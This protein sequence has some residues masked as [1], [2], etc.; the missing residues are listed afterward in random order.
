[1]GKTTIS[2]TDMTWSPLRVRVR[3][4]AAQIARANGY[5]S[6]IQIAG[7][8]AGHVGPHCEHV[9]D[10]CKN[11]YS[12]TNNGRCLPANGTG[13]PFDRRSRDLVY[14]F[15]D[16]NILTQ[17]LRWKKP[18]RVFVENQSDLFG[19][20]VPDE[21][22]DRVF[23]VMQACHWNTFQCLTKRP[24]RALA[25]LTR[26]ATLRMGPWTT[27]ADRARWIAFEDFTDKTRFLYGTKWP[28]PNIW[29]GISCEDQKTADERSRY[30][31]QVPAVVR[32]ISQE[33]QISEIDWAPEALSGIHWLVQG[34]ESGLGARPFWVDWAR[35]TKQQCRAASVAYFLKQIGRFPQGNGFPDLDYR[36]RDK[37]GESMEEW[38]L[39]VRVREFPV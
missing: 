12:G 35:K 34:G 18:R 16:E 32:F 17:P 4:N 13:L 5:A 33:P 23:A 19:E 28:I 1:M 24:V 31:R 2:W 8:M 29:I 36:K 27:E 10:G 7:K 22:I 39:D 9:S 11:C 15:V 20:W 30:L 25:Y 37:K 14:P 26:L 3:D 6:L 21:A 38:P